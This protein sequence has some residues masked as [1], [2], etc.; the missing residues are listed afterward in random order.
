MEDT[1]RQTQHYAELLKRLPGVYAARVRLDTDDQIAEVHL[2]AGM[3]RHPKQLVRDARTVLLSA[4]DL[5][6]DYQ[7]F[8]VAQL[9]DA[10]GETLGEAPGE[11]VGADADADAGTDA[12]KR[13][14]LGNV[15]QSV[16]NGRYSVCV[17]LSASEQVFTGQCD[18]R[19]TPLQRQRAVAS[20]VL[21]AVNQTLNPDHGVFTAM[22]VQRVATTPVP[23]VVVLV[24]CIEKDRSLLLVGAAEHTENEALSIEKATLDAINR[25]LSRLRGHD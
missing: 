24:E 19:N 18:V 23:V 1:L 12:I 8:S 9:S 3:A 22:A 20:A 11:N 6:V 17:S 5:D 10:L 7:K 25:K 16:V 4:F 21:D 15:E 2:L 13:L 14:C